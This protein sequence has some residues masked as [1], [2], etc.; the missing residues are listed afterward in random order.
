MFSTWSIR[1]RALLLGGI[2]PALPLSIL[3]IAD[4]G[5]GVNG[6][7]SFLIILVASMSLGLVVSVF[8]FDCVSSAL[9]NM[10][11]YI[12]EAAQENFKTKCPKCSAK[13]LSNLEERLY[14][15]IAKLKLTIGNWNGFTEAV[16]IP[17]AFVDPKGNLTFCNQMALEMLERDGKPSDYAGMYFSEFFYSDRNRKAAIVEIMER[18][19]AEVRDVEFK[20]FKGNTRHVR[21]ALSPLHDLDGKLSGGLC[22]YLDFTELYQKEEQV[23]RQGESIL[24]AMRIVDGISSELAETSKNLLSKVDGASKGAD[25]QTRRA[26]ETATAMEE[27]NSTV[28]EVARNASHAAETANKAKINAGDGA[29][30]VEELI[31]FSDIVLVNAKQSLD[32][33]GMLG[34]Q[35][36]GIGNILNVIS[37]IADQTNLLAL[38]AAIEAARAGDAGRGFAVVADEVRKLAEKT[39][40]ATREVGAVIHGIQLGT[41]KNYDHVEQAVAALVEVTQLAGKSGE[42]MKKILN[43]V[44]STSDQI[45]SIATASE[46]QSATSEEINRSIEDVSRISSETSGAM[47]QST[48]VVGEVANQAQALKDLIDQMKD[49]REQPGTATKELD[50]NKKLALSS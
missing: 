21:I 37:D 33:M 13:E 32:D 27:M 42:S 40:V 29:E 22:I 48:H 38:N 25:A 8:S 9:I 19:K 35:A 16:L 43:F 6:T 41:K 30:I 34:K 2:L 28:L 15:L 31:K 14:S 36:D 45:R 26:E 23:A 49:E 44:E 7:I 20:N 39:M 50:L 3:F 47:R 24:N 10:S 46:Q 11:H 1:A 17:Y 18:N 5:F 4:K 12:N